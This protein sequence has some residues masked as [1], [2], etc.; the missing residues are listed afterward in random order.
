MDK[1][2]CDILT[3]IDY[4]YIK[5]D[6]VFGRADAGVSLDS[7][8]KAHAIRDIEIS[9]WPNEVMHLDAICANTP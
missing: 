1:C 3:H 4:L 6:S 7:V 9:Q 2:E 8:P 5:T